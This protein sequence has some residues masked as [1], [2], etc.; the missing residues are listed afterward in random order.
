MAQITI[1]NLSFRYSLGNKNCLEK[2]NLKINEGEFVILCGKSGCGKTT[3]LRQ[4]KPAIAPKGERS[5]KIYFN[6]IE[7]DKIDLRTQSEK[8]GFVMQN[9][10]SQIVTDKVWHELA[11]ALE[12]LGMKT[13]EIRLR[14]AEMAS[15]FGIDDWFDKKTNELSGGQKQ[16][17]NLAAVMA[18]HP[19]VLILDEPTSRLDPIAAD[20]FLETVNKINK[21]LGVTVII[22]EHR[23][24]NIFS[25][26]D[27][28]VVM[29][30]GKIVADDEP[31]KIGK[32]ANELPELVKLSL[33]AAMKIFAATGEK[34]EAPVCV[35]DGRK[36][37][38]NQNIFCKKIERNKV[39][40]SEKNAIELK[41]IS[42]KYEKN[43]DDVL[44]S[45]SLKIPQG[46][47]FAL[48]G[49]NGVGKSTLFKIILGIEKPYSGKIKINGTVAAMPQEVQAL[50]ASRTVAEELREMSSDGEQIKN[51]AR[52]TQIESLTGSHPFDLSGGEQQR[53][54]VAKLLLCES[55]IYFFDEPTKGMDAEFKKIFSD[56]LFELRAKNKTVII[57]SHDIDFCAENAE[58]C[59]MLFDKNISAVNTTDE[60]FD[61]NRFYTTAANKISKG[62]IDGA[63]TDKD[64][65]EC[66]KK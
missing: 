18:M 50:F 15:Y 58:L 29:D 19:D 16:I 10:E 35:R 42:F 32:T 64:V 14:V 7:L 63:I 44:S 45:L 21:D 8:I 22:T 13:S 4:L 39:N 47:V 3:L 20:R 5:G 48:L 28:I 33:P 36:W 38:K 55:D 25:F 57:I 46:C 59:A 11:F 2:I 23:L 26:A 9:P 43:S 12:N 30:S 37:I 49:G 62:F 52:L 66:L 31:K 24:E 34:G 61:G 54:A 41:N 65:I 40:F 6:D 53:V 56:I 60:F 17:L 27:R 1:E 51:A